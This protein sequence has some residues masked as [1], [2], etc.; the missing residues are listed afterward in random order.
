MIFMKEDTKHPLLISILFFAFSL[1]FIFLFIISI[2]YYNA[3]KT[4]YDDLMYGEF[5][6]KSIRE[7]TDPD[8]GNMYYIDVV[9]DERNIKVNNLLTNKKVIEG[10]LS[11]KSDDMIYCYFVNSSSYYEIVELKTEN[12][13][14]LSLD[15]YNEIYNRQ[16]TL[17]IVISPIMFVIMF[18]IAVKALWHMQKE[19][20]TI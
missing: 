8:M 13:T 18:G 3:S 15:D 4:T 19:R 11:L 9:E 5:T 6:V 12:R 17:G 1:A 16:G 2:N 14:I 20:T 7:V 10:I